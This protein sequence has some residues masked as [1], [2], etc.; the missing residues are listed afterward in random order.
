MK[1]PQNAMFR[2]FFNDFQKLMYQFDCVQ[3]KNTCTVL[4]GVGV[5]LGAFSMYNHR[6][7]A[8]RKHPIPAHRIC[9]WRKLQ[10]YGWFCLLLRF[11][12]PPHCRDVTAPYLSIAQVM[13]PQSANPD[14]WGLER[15][16]FTKSWDGDYVIFSFFT[17]LAVHIVVWWIEWPSRRGWFHWVNVLTGTPITRPPHHH[18]KMQRH[19]TLIP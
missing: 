10:W 16:D 7:I 9:R 6:E 1:K 17:Q 13:I 5:Q 19:P 11:P 4:Q 3:D 12:W 18:A 14:F 15:P 2:G 8:P